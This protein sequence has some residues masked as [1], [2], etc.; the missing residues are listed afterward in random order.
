LQARATPWVQAIAST[1]PL[2]SGNLFLNLD[3]PGTMQLE[4][5]VGD[6]DDGDASEAFQYLNDSPLLAVA[7]ACQSEVPHHVSA[8]D[9]TI[10]TER[11]SPFAR[12]IAAVIRAS[13]VFCHLRARVVVRASQF[14]LWGRSAAGLAE[15]T[16]R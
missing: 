12:A 1:S 5:A 4:N 9:S 11:K 13:H 2:S 15:E 3:L 14:P 10:S 7:S 16:A 8:I 6:L